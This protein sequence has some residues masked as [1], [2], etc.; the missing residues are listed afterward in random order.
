MKNLPIG[1]QTFQKLID[2]NSIYVDK[3]QIL[4]R[5]VTQGAYYFL[6]RP[7]RA[8]KSLLI[9]T[10][11]ELFKGNKTLFK[12]LWIEPHWDWSQS[13]PVVHLSFDA[14][15]YQ[16]QSLAECLTEELREC[17]KLY[18]IELTTNS[19]KQQFKELLKKLSEKHGRVVLL[20]DEYDKPIIDYL[21]AAK[22]EQAK[23]NRDTL[24]DFYGVLKSSDG[25]L[26]FVFITGISKFSRISLFSHLNNLEDITVGRSFAA[27]TGYTQ[28]EL[29]FYFAEY[30]E[31]ICKTMKITRE[32]LLEQM[33]IWYNGYSWDGDV[34]V[35][36][37]FG[38]LNFLKKQ[39]FHNYWIATGNPRFLMDQMKNMAHFNMENISVNSIIFEKFDIENIEIISLMF[40]TGYLTIKARDPRPSYYI[41]DYP[42]KEVRDSMYQF[43]MDDLA[44]SIYRKDTGRVMLDL[45]EAFLTKNLKQV[46]KIL[47]SILADLPSE[48]YIKQ[49]EGLY[50]GLVHIIFSYLGTFIQSEVHSS[51]GHADTVVETP[52]D[53]FL[54]E[55]KFNK[56]ADAALTQIEENDYAGKYRASGKTITAIG[57]NF[58]EKARGVD[59]WKEKTI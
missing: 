58:S 13:S 53:V 56:T 27:L 7:R 4:H 38:T 54:F 11:K 32:E 18:D 6:S 33:K 35:Y 46:R 5:L 48:A 59:D 30:L 24:R 39:E 28:E 1:I 41:L 55:F 12:D 57:V 52:T 50:H 31:D 8:G 21:E 9:S 34:K 23:A 37:P 45:N 20:I 2:T 19:F 3:T 40:Q 49:T 51:Q 36:N 47:E 10:F 14:M 15:D 25:N 22:I 42:N 44:P 26:R 43:L 29:E 17:A 16:T